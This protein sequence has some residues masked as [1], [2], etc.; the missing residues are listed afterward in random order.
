VL[1]HYDVDVEAATLRKRASLKMPSVGQYAW[2]HPSNR[3]L[4]VSTTDSERG[5]KQITGAQHCLSALRVGRDG[6]LA[7]H[8]EPQLLRQRPINN[9][10]DQSGRYALTAYNAPPHLTVHPINAD[11]TLGAPI[12][13][14]ADLDLG[15][16]RIR[17]GHCHRTAPWSW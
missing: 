4:Y 5:S 8:G 1:T 6:A 2:P 9:S 15:I 10:V 14:P 13:Q 16:F 12:A 11:G 7:R 3:Y 17:F